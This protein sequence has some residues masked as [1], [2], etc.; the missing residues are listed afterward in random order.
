MGLPDG[1]RDA[2]ADRDALEREPGPGGDRLDPRDATVLKGIGILAIVLH[3]YFHLL[4]S[5]ATENEFNFNPE[6]FR[7]FLAV[8]AD[9]HQTIQALFA[10]FGHFGVQLFI[11]LSAY[12]LA[13]KYWTVPSWHRFVWSRIRKIYPTWFLVL[14]VYLLLKLVQDGP[15]HLAAFLQRQGDELVLTTLGV[16]TLLP[17]YRLPPVGPWWFLPFI[18]QFYC[19]WSVLTWFTRRFGGPDH[20]GVRRGD[21]RQNGRAAG[22]DRV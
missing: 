1:P 15:A 13:L 7:H 4:P 17:G 18:M 6:R 10:Y 22:S 11:F 21:V 20:G 2:L 8:A 9:P 14:G 16:I 5:A 19:L 12:G 3:N